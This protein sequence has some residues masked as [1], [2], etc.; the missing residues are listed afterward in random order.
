MVHTLG[1]PAAGILR[2]RQLSE[3]P[4]LLAASGPLPKRRIDLI[5]Y[6][7]GTLEPLLLVECKA[8]PLTEQ[9]VHQVLGYNAYVQAPFVAV[10]NDNTVYFCGQS[11]HSS[12]LPPYEQLVEWLCA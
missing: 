7:R 1:Y 5:S 3:L 11:R 4:H 8:V 12:E 6:R 9:A 2:E 10:V